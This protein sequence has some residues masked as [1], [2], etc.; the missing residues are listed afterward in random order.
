MYLPKYP[1]YDSGRA[2]RVLRGKPKTEWHIGVDLGKRR[3]FSAF[4][5]L[6]LSWVNTGRCPVTFAWNFVPS[7]AL[8]ALDRFPLGTDYEDIPR[9]LGRRVD[10]INAL[11]R[12]YL[13]GVPGKNVAIDGGGPGPPV[14]DRIRRRLRDQVNVRPVF[15]TGGNTQSSLS[16]GYTGV[17]RRMLISNVLLLLSNGTLELPPDLDHCETLEEE[18]S[19]LS[20]GSSQ[21]VTS[22]AHDDLVMALALGVWSALKDAPELLPDCPVVPG[23]SEEGWNAEAKRAVPPPPEPEKKRKRTAKR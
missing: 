13:D 16:D 20:G 8:L 19:N 9:M 21:P 11:P 1:S 3:D 15:I 4:G 7:L 10:Q 5:C 6:E 17:P 2:A 23:E 12:A 14:I 22:D 18:F